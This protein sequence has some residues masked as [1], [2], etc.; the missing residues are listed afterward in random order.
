M[1]DGEHLAFVIDD[2]ALDTVCH[3]AASQ[4]M[5]GRRATIEETHLA[6]LA[7]EPGGHRGQGSLG[8][9]PVFRLFGTRP[10]DF[11]NAL[12]DDDPSMT[13]IM[14]T[15]QKDMRPIEVHITE[16]ETDEVRKCLGG[17]SILNAKLIG[18]SANGKVIL[19]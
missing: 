14:T 12:L 15:S 6:I 5:H 4:R 13:T 10:H 3:V 17:C 18:R 1:R 16:K 9:L 19:P 8:H 11:G 7:A 2:A